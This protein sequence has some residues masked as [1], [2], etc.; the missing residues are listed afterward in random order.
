MYKKRALVLWAYLS[1]LA[2]V[3][4][5]PK[6]VDDGDLVTVDYIY[7]FENWEVIEQWTSDFIVW[8]SWKLEWIESL[9]L[10][11]KQED[12]F[13]WTINWREVFSSDYNPNL[14]QSYPNIVMTEVLWIENPVVW[15]EIEVNSLWTWII[16]RIE[17]DKD[18]YDMYVVEFNDPKTY[19]NILYEIKVVNI[20]KR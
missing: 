12:A 6:V 1:L 7:S 9:V 13:D 18:W 20:E 2:L 15:S 16:Q 11:A 4:C 17:K 3:A 14:V 19:S 5:G 10:W 8:E